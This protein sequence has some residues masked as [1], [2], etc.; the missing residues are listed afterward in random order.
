MCVVGVGVSPRLGCLH[1]IALAAACVRSVG[2][3]ACRY[4]E[5]KYVD[6]QRVVDCI[7]QELQSWN[8]SPTSPPTSTK[9]GIHNLPRYCKPAGAG[10]QFDRGRN[11]GHR[12][13]SAYHPWS[14]LC[15]LEA[16][17]GPEISALHNSSAE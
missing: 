12:W 17:A 15:S 4:V 13:N 8:D 10:V 11:L 1:R 16:P 5:L 7:A 2:V 3:H 9:R 14:L 6:V